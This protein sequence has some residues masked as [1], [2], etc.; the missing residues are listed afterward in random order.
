M[1][2]KGSH[3]PRKWQFFRNFI[4]SMCRTASILLG[5]DDPDKNDHL[6]FSSLPPLWGVLSS[7]GW[8]GRKFLS[9]E[10]ISHSVLS[11]NTISVRVSAPGW[12]FE[13]PELKELCVNSVTKMGWF[14][15]SLPKIPNLFQWDPCPKEP[16]SPKI[17][18]ELLISISSC[19]SPW[20]CSQLSVPEFINFIL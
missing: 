17:R 19:S 3:V 10:D 6:Y 16:H 20:C 9:T 5:I 13:V 8:K 11:P 4:I 15:P 7:L 14:P 1:Y 18:A 2:F 12:R